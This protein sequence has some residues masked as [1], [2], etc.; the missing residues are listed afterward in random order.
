MSAKW[1]KFHCTTKAL[2]S[3]IMSFRLW[4]SCSV[5]NFIALFHSVCPHSVVFGNSE[6]LFS[7]KKIKKPT[8]QYLLSIKQTQLATR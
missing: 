1:I 6:Q 5:H 2:Q 7:E 8:V 4:F 3:I